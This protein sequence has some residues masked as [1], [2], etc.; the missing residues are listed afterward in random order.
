MADIINVRYPN[1]KDFYKAM[2]NAMKVNK[3]SNFVYVYD[4]NE[5]ENMRKLILIDD[6]SAGVA[7]KYNGDIISVFKNTDVK[8]LK[9]VADLLLPLAIINGGYKLDCFGEFLEEKYMNSGFIPVAKVE[10]SVENAPISWNYERDGKPNIY[11]CT[12]FTNAI[13]KLAKITMGG[14][15]FLGFLL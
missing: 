2:V 7:V 6:G 12:L 8:N 9:N 3:R 1:N 11:F 10:F 14:G 4:M 15:Q 5:Y 13:D